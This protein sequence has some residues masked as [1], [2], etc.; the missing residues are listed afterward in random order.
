MADEIGHGDGASGT[1]LKK[2]SEVL[3]EFLKDILLNWRSDP[4][5]SRSGRFFQYFVAWLGAFHLSFP[6]F[7]MNYARII[8]GYF[9][10]GQEPPL[11]VAGLIFAGVY[12]VLPALLV[13]ANVKRQTGVRI[14]LAGFFL[15]FTT[16]AFVARFAP[17]IGG[18]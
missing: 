10:P 3:A 6:A 7:L 9:P 11:I 4:P 18:S 12:S 16:W 13:G 17:Q 15:T 8:E 5:A 2:V 14:Y 1:E